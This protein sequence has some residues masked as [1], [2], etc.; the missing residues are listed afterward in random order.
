MTIFC[1][2]RLFPDQGTDGSAEAYF[3]YQMT[4]AF[5]IMWLSDEALEVNL[6]FPVNGI[7][8]LPLPSSFPSLLSPVHRHYPPD[9]R[10]L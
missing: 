3:N 10:R 5:Y 8:I 9:E 1:V 2:E 6:Y 4:V 7:L